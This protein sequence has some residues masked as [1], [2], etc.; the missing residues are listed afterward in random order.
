MLA[1]W[2]PGIIIDVY[3]QLLT[4]YTHVLERVRLSNEPQFMYEISQR[5]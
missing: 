2:L 3:M 5:N 4:E 1:A